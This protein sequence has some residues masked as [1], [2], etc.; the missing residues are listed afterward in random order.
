MY[1][2]I[3]IVT[4]I[5]ISTISYIIQIRGIIGVDYL[6]IRCFKTSI[7]GVRKWL[8]AGPRTDCMQPAGQKMICGGLWSYAFLDWPGVNDKL[9][10]MYIGMRANFL[11]IDQF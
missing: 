8:P 11:L 7:P 10:P 1:V 2:C 6:K 9:C 5:I 4:G 3:S